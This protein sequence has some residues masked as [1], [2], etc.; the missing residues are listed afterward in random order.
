MVKLP[1]GTPV[2]HLKS[3]HYD[4]FLDAKMVGR[5]EGNP[6]NGDLIAVGESL[7]RTTAEWEAAA[8]RLDELRAAPP[9][10]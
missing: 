8:T 5:V 9:V 7:A 1:P 10:S 6:R 3:A 4:T 2:A